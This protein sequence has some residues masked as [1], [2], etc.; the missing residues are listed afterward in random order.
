MII[1]TF[2]FLSETLIKKGIDVKKLLNDISDFQ[3]AIPSW[4]LGTGGHGLEDSLR[5]VNQQ[6]WKTKLK[7]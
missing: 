2:E 4:A 7:M 3:V 1:K 6:V 5:G